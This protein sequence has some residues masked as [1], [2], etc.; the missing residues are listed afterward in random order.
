MCC[1]VYYQRFTTENRLFEQYFIVHL[2]VFNSEIFR[3]DLLMCFFFALLFFFLLVNENKRM[4]VENEN[5]E[6]SQ[7]TKTLIPFNTASHSM[8]IVDFDAISHIIKNQLIR[9]YCFI[10]LLSFSS[11]LFHCCC[12]L[13]C[14]SSF[15][16]WSDIGIL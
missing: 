13:F 7:K 10:T 16:V 6:G 12:W 11:S 8:E 9:F 3:I 2:F 1:T 4:A 15:Q 14:L 5:C